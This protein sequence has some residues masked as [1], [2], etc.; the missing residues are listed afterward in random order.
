M[1]VKW[2]VTSLSKSFTETCDCY[3]MVII[4][5]NVAFF[6]WDKCSE[7]NENLRFIEA[8]IAELLKCLTYSVLMDDNSVTTCIRNVKFLKFVD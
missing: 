3:F 8:E 7:S 4:S 2:K 5:R 6:M 1:V